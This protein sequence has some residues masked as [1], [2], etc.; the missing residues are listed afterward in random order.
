MVPGK[1]KKRSQV[2]TQNTTEAQAKPGN[3]A[4]VEVWE[5][6]GPDQGR[7]SAAMSLKFK[8]KI[9]FEDK[10][11]EITMEITEFQGVRKMALNDHCFLSNGGQ[12]P[13]MVTLFC[14]GHW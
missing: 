11:F 10:I 7:G 8:F 5:P 12:S 4:A 14:G 9:K 1:P 2:D 13:A 6:Q 3:V